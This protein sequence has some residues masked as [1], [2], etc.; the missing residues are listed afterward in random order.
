MIFFQKK[1]KIKN[2]GGGPIQLV[3]GWG[4]TPQPDGDG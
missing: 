1:L 2:F 4:A 3:W